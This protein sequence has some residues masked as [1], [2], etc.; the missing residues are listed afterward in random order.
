MKEFWCPL[1]GGSGLAWIFGPG[2]SGFW[3]LGFSGLGHRVS[4]HRVHDPGF[5]PFGYAVESLG[6]G[7]RLKGSKMGGFRK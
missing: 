7:F 6:L 3:G 4:E 5:S 1:G 2:G